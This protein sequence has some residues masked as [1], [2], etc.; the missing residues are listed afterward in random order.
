MHSTARDGQQTKPSAQ[1]ERGASRAANHCP[2]SDG[3]VNQRR[4]ASLVSGAGV[5]LQA[6]CTQEMDPEMTLDR[7]CNRDRERGAARASSGAWD[8]W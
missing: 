3:P 6:S 4:K 5:A 2:A 8:G 7:G 1:K